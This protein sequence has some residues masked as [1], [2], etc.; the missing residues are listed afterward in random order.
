MLGHLVLV[1][2]PAHKSTGDFSLHNDRVRFAE[3]PGLTYSGIARYKC[4]FFADA[5]PGRFS[6]APMLF[7]A[8]RRGELSGNLYE[9]VWEDVGS[10]QRLAQ[11]N[12]Q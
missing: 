10:P 4:E 2:T 5:E 12:R 9:G 1:P 8:A 11:I 7:D 6:V 3:D